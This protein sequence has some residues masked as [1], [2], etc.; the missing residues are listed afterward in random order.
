[1]TMTNAQSNTRVWR[2]D[3][4]WSV[5][6]PHLPKNPTG[7]PRKDDR[8]ILRGILPVRHSGCRW[9]DGPPAYG[10]ATTGST[11]YPRGA[12]RGIWAGRFRDLTALGGTPS[13]PSLASTLITAPRSASGTTG[14]AATPSATAEADAR[15]TFTPPRTPT[16]VRSRSC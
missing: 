9:Q 12:Q 2:D 10:P 3:L 1:M 13:E 6:E 5:R 14:A 15:R 4:H 8:R 11:R 16:A 7:P